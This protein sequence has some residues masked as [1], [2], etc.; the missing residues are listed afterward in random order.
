MIFK[1]LLY[2][3]SIVTVFLILVFSPGKSNIGS[4][5]DQSKLLNFGYN[6]I[7]MQKIIGF[8]IFVF[9]VLVVVLL[10]KVI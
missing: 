10:F 6:Q 2:A 5:A 1:M 7:L 9:F 4:L 8:S 3:V